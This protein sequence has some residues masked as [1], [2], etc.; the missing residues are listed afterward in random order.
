MLMMGVN[1]NC[2]VK[3]EGS[4]LGTPCL[5][6]CYRGL[7]ADAKHTD[8]IGACLHK[9]DTSPHLRGAHIQVY[10]HRPWELKLV[11]PR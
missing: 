9:S 10:R 7:R 2:A 6:V 4:A 1:V 11:S 5:S 3:L 8:L